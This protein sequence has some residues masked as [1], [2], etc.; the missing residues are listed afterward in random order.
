MKIYHYVTCL[1]GLAVAVLFTVALRADEPST[2]KIILAPDTQ[3]YAMNYPDTFYVQMK[4][5]ADHADDIAFV[6]QQGDITNNNTEAQWNVAAFSFRLLDGKVPYV[7]ALGNHD[8]GKQGSTDS[9]NSLANQ[10]FPDKTYSKIKGF[11]GAFESGKIDNTW[12]TFRA[13]GINWLVLSLE[14]GPR[15]RILDWA[16]QIVKKYPKHKI[17]VNTHAYRDNNDIRMKKGTNHHP[18]SYPI[19]KMTGED[20]V[21]DG[22][23][24]WEKFVSQYPN[25]M[26]V[27]SGHVVGKGVGRRVDKGKHGNDV[28]QILANYQV[29]K[30]GG[31]G[32]LRI[33]TLDLP[34]KT[35]DV[36]TYSPLLNKYLEEPDHQFM[37]E[38]VDFQ[39]K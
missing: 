2:F 22:E 11:G 20:S 15:N 17:I 33:L 8:Y 14:F 37:F 36:K 10:F 29:R 28:Y 7:L 34:N 12:F 35:I 18:Q 19:G 16:D 24:M 39:I 13:G 27:F 3:V 25:M 30:Q 4:W 38:N 6:L 21:N 9:R 23:M 5:I 26:F 1:F 31:E 32:Y